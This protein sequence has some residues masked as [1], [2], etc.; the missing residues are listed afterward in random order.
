MP[1][2][3]L[4]D[5]ATGLR[6]AVA[7][8]WGVATMAYGQAS[9]EVASVRLHQG[10]GGTI[11]IEASGSR[12]TA[13]AETVASLLMYAYDLKSYQVPQTAALVPFGDSFY[14]IAAIAEGTP[15]DSAFRQMMQSLLADRFAL[16][17]HHERREVPVYAL[18][19]G[20]SGPKLRESAPNSD[21]AIS[22]L[23]S[24]RNWELKMPRATMNDVIRAIENSLVDRPVIDRTG[25]TGTYDIVMTYTPQTPANRKSPDPDDISIFEA[26]QKHGL[27]LEPQKALVDTLVVDHVEKPSPN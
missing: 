11:R 18:V 19:V 14:D 9:F 17:A 15:P 7:I 8:V 12:L 24:G 1:A 16:K 23:A 22:Y 3:R 13:E 25:L 2:I 26:V 21:P 27:R 10:H 5:M 20:K 6:L 4:R